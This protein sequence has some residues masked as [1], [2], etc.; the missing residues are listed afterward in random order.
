MLNI[1]ILGA[2]TVGSGVVKV[3]SEKKEEFEAKVGSPLKIKKIAVKDLTK[4]RPAYFNGIEITDD[5]EEIVKDPEIDIVVELIGGEEPARTLLVEAINRG[6]HIVTANKEVIAKHG[7]EIFDLANEKKI[8]VY[9][10]GSV[11]GGI[12]IIQTLKRDLI[13]NK[14]NNLMG[15]INGTTNFILTEMTQKKRDFYDVLKEAKALGYAEADPTSDIEGY[16]PVYKLS[17][18]ASLVFGHKINLEE[19]YREGITKITVRDIENAHRL[20]YIIKLL[21]IAKQHDDGSYEARVHPTMLPSSHPLASVNGSF[22]AIWLNGDS[23]GDFMLYGRGAGQLPTAS[24]VVADILNVAIEMKLRT[25]LTISQQ[26]EY[27]K[28]SSM[29]KVTSQYYLRISTADRPGVMG[30][31]GR[32]LG[33][34]NVSIS[35]LWQAN[36]DGRTAEI[37]LITHPVLEENMNKAISLL[38][39]SEGIKEINSLIRVEE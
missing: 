33:I 34:S 27:I 26:K 9:I 12:P 28:I 18:L 19:I 36:T 24:A 21:A 8:S 23:V 15:I 6:K 22:N 7:N 29:D 17:I 32:D 13:A 1:G 11:A 3:L 37:V 25:P 4:E 35:S 16:D 31:I 2:G 14:V 39:D 38:K 5:P 30:I 20:G 10:E